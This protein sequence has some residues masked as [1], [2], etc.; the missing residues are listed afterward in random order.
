MLGL[1]QQ[2][3]GQGDGNADGVPPLQD[4]VDGIC[5]R[6]LGVC[7]GKQL[8]PADYSTSSTPLAAAT[9]PLEKK[10]KKKKKSKNKKR[11]KKK[12]PL[13]VDEHIEL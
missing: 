1:S 11:H 10:K 2:E 4:A 12:V 9:T 13:V 3:G 5:S 8:E 6:I 7:D